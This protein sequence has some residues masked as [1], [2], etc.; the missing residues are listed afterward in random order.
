[1]KQVA[2][3]KGSSFASVDEGLWRDEQGRYFVG[4]EMPLP[5]ERVQEM[6]SSDELEWL[7]GEELVSAAAEEIAEKTTSKPAKSACDEIDSGQAPPK[8]SLDAVI[9]K[10]SPLPWIAV[11]VAIV[12]IGIAAVAF[13]LNQSDPE[14]Q[15]VEVPQAEQSIE[16]TPEPEPIQES[17]PG[18]DVEESE[19]GSSLALSRDFAF[20]DFTQHSDWDWGARIDLT[21]WGDYDDVSLIAEI[22]FYSPNEFNIYWGEFTDDFLEPGGGE[23]IGQGFAEGNDDVIVF[24]YSLIELQD[25]IAEAIESQI[26]SGVIYEYQ[27][28]FAMGTWGTLELSRSGEIKEF[29]FQR[30]N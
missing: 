10:K 4:G 11:I 6:E 23:M 1:M 28:D 21:M 9:D 18:N 29:G 13:I 26:A 19:I 7:P 8:E 20:T 14:V 12:V 30:S 25:G 24:N 16:P 17:E 15:V 5:A 2:K 3:F 22:R 27:V